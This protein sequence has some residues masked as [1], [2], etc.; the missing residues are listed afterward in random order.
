MRYSAVFF[1]LFFSSTVLADGNLTLFGARVD[2]ESVVNAKRDAPH[3]TG[4]ML[5][6]RN[7]RKVFV[8]GDIMFLAGEYGI[9]GK[10]G[11]RF[12]ET[13]AVA[14]GLGWL[15]SGI[16]ADVFVPEFGVTSS[17]DSEFLETWFVE[18]TSKRFF[19]RYT[20]LRGDYKIE[21]TR[22]IEITPGVL[23]PKTGVREVSTH[24]QALFIGLRIPLT[25]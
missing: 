22:F 15:N 1:L 17:G 2:E 5:S 12:G 16:T 25:P 18:Y 4:I 8:G 21:A 19:V 3:G 10:I 20:A 7:N 6:A 9:D 13:S 24:D 11:F 14:F 23:A